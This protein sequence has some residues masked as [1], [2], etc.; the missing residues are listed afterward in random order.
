MRKIP[1]RQII[2][3]LILISVIGIGVMVYTTCSGAPLVQRIDKTLPDVSAAPY[4]VSTVTHIY[5]ARQATKDARGV[6]MLN[7]YERLN[8]KWVLHPEPITIPAN[9]RPNISKR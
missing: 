1:F 6:T 5:Y 8:K 7:W 4:E 9:L 3:I 2:S